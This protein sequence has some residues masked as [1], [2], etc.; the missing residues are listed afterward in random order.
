MNQYIITF[1]TAV[2]SII[3]ARGLGVQERGEVAELVLLFSW[4]FTIHSL[5]NP[6]TMQYRVS[7]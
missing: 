2:T 1:I 3:L 5:M 6:G 4:F 7:Q